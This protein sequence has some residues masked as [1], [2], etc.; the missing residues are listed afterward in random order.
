MEVAFNSALGLSATLESVGFEMGVAQLS[1]GTLH[2]VI[3]LGGSK[4]LPVLSIQTNQDLVL[5]G[6]P[7]PGVLPLSLNISDQH[8]VVRE[9]ESQQGS[10]H[11]F[12]AGLSDVFFQLPAGAHIQVVLVSQT[13]FE[14]LATSTGDH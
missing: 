10:L 1:R 6:N 4:Q 11:G 12:Q 8:P 7:R 13:R 9:E 5:H 3:R 2:G 14:Q